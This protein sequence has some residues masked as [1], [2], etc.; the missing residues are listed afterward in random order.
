MIRPLQHP[1]PFVGDLSTQDAAALTTM[2]RGA[3]VLE[4]GCGGSTQIFASVAASV[5]SYETDP[6]WIEKTQRNLARLDLADKVSFR[7]YHQP[8]SQDIGPFD[9]IFV[10]GAP[11]SRPAFALSAFPMLVDDGL[12]VFHDCRTPERDVVLRTAR[13]F[14]NLV[15]E[16][17]FDVAQSNLAVIRR[18]PMPAYENWNVTEGRA[19][20]EYGGPEEDQPQPFADAVMA[21]S[22]RFFRA[23]MVPVPPCHPNPP[24][25]DP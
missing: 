13:E 12:M 23:G 1:A 8:M 15:G 24:Q 5:T 17:L 21:R 10:D 3:R 16:V 9:L 20:W 4:F 25:H 6:G 22:A 18:K 11:D 14:M 7:S 2:A 19:H